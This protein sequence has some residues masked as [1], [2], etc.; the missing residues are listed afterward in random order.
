MKRKI[1]LRR[2]CIY[3]SIL[4]ALAGA[5]LLLLGNSNDI[6]LCTVLGSVL[7]LSG[8]ILLLIAC[9]YT[10]SIGD[11]CICVRIPLFL[12]EVIEIHDIIKC[13]KIIHYSSDEVA[14]TLLI[15]HTRK[16]RFCFFEWI[17]D[18]VEIES[19]LK[20][21]GVKM[22]RNKPDISP[23]LECDLPDVECEALCYRL[24][25]GKRIIQP[26]CLIV[27]SII[28][29]S[30]LANNR[31]GEIILFV[32]ASYWYYLMLVFHDLLFASGARIVG[33]SLPIVNIWS[34]LC[35]KKDYAFIILVS[36]SNI[37]IWIAIGLRFYT[38]VFVAYNEEWILSMLFLVPICWLRM[39]EADNVLRIFLI[40]LISAFITTAYIPCLELGCSHTYQ[41]SGTLM[42][43]QNEEYYLNFTDIEKEYNTKAPILYKSSELE[44]RDVTIIVYKTILGGTYAREI[45]E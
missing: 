28:V 10:V 38:S 15:L 18:S 7:L 11:H 35:I 25:L 23:G 45:K 9:V 19:W 16:R 14:T 29:M 17:M 3:K 32:A 33:K 31:F 12:H 37:L 39:Y 21:N 20:N 8:L 40:C 6:L 4:A 42:V 1:H 22:E 44:T 26:S 41:T 13:K 43:E 2:S 5:L 34:K 30:C 36:L 27:S 24:E